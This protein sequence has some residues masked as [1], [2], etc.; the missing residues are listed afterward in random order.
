MDVQDERDVCNDVSE[1]PLRRAG[2]KPAPTVR[3]PL[4]VSSFG[5]R[6]GRQLIS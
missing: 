3:V 4:F 2:F 1:H 5:R 6:G